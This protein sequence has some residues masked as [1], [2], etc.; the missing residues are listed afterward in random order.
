[1]KWGFKLYSPAWAGTLS[2]AGGLVFAGDMEGYVIA[3]DAETGEALWRFQT[4]T[5]IFTAPMTYLLDGGVQ[6]LRR[7]GLPRL[8]ED[9][10]RWNGKTD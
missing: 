3:L 4:G 9:L 1:M 10:R 8:Y 5:A 7:P 6:K 2:T